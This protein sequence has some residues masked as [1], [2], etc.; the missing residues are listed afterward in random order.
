MNVPEPATDESDADD[1]PPVGREAI[2]ASEDTE[3]IPPMTTEPTRLAEDADAF[4]QLG[5]KSKNESFG[6]RFESSQTSLPLRSFIIATFIIG[7][8]HILL[9]TTIISSLLRYSQ[10]TYMRYHGISSLTLVWL[11]LGIKYALQG[12][13][14]LQS[15]LLLSLTIYCGTT[16]SN[17]ALSTIISDG[18]GA[19]DYFGM[20]SC[21]LYLFWML[22][23]VHM[24]RREGMLIRN[25]V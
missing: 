13:I 3:D 9:P 19:F 4:G 24:Q 6:Q 22:G 2:S 1:R 15:T 11:T 12:D 21:F 5:Q 18:G 23:L 25:F 20:T 16:L 10:S 7:L 8:T 17:L 14:E